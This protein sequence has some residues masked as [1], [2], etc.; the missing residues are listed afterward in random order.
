MQR[1]G[2][3][4]PGAEPERA[5]SSTQVCLILPFL[6]LDV[7]QCALPVS[8]SQGQGQGLPASLLRLQST[9]WAQAIFG[10]SG[11][12]SQLLLAK[13]PRLLSLP[14]WSSRS[15]LPL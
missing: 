12:I 3:S 7:P 6:A 1:P 15:V 2:C 9:L 4:L 10:S 11:D 8:V 14:L 13:S 5:S